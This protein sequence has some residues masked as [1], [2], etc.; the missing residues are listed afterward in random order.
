LLQGS[1]KFLQK[2][3]PQEPT[4]PRTFKTKAT[5]EDPDFIFR[6]RKGP[7]PQPKTNSQS[8]NGWI[9]AQWLDLFA[10]FVR[11]SWPLVGFRTHL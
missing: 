4:G 1:L 5:T 7:I 3:R 9:S 8:D 10:W 11:L 2:S 6:N